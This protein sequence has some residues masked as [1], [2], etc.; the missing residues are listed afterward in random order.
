MSPRSQILERQDCSKNLQ[1][2]HIW[3]ER[4]YVL[5][6]LALDNEF[7][8]IFW[9]LYLPKKLEKALLIQ[10]H[11]ISEN[12]WHVYTV[13]SYHREVYEHQAQENWNRDVSLHLLQTHAFWLHTENQ[14]MTYSEDT[15]CVN[16]CISNVTQRLMTFTKQ[17]RDV[18][19]I[20]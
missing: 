14:Y 4:C 17:G 9:Y 1:R 13:I 2:H 10:I 11:R 3:I 8:W 12:M 16:T 18:F 20:L 5:W 7:I 6:M 15:A 19:N